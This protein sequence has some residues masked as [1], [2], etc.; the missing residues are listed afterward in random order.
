MNIAKIENVGT[1]VSRSAFE[2]YISRRTD[3]RYISFH[4][5]GALKALRRVVFS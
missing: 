2:F 5:M 4:R 1:G 3:I